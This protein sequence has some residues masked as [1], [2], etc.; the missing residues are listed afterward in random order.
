MKKKNIL[1]SKV[2]KM[3]GAKVKIPLP[4]AA[5]YGLIDGTEVIIGD[6]GEG[7]TIRKK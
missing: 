3:D 2:G 5:K 4:F 7:L 6:D 1:D